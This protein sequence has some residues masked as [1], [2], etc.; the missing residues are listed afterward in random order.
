ME[1]TGYVHRDIRKIFNEMPIGRKQWT[2]FLICFAATAIEGFDTIVISFIAPAI[3]HQWQLSSAALSPLVAFGLS[4][5]L[6]GS[7]AGGTLAD[8]VG[9]RTVSIVAI[10]WFGIAG[11]VSS[12]AQSIVQLVALRFITGIGIGAAMPATSALVAEYSPDRSRSAM[13]ASTYCGFLFGAAAAGFVTSMAIGSLG[14]RGMLLLS[15]LMPLI[16][17]ALLAWQ[18]P[19]SPLYIVA[20]RK[21]NEVAHRILGK[22]F[23]SSDFTGMHL[24]IAETRESIRGSRAL[25]SDAYR[26]GTVL[27]WVTE[28]AGYLV[29]FLI[30]SWLPTH[31][32]QAGLSMHDASQISSM[33]QFGA[34]GGAVLFAFLVR[35]Y[36]VATVIAGAFGIGALLVIVLGMSEAAPWHV[37]VVFLSGL[38]VGGPLICVNTIPGIF[39]PTALRASGGGWNVAIGRLG[40]IVGSSLIGLIVL[41]GFPFLFTCALLSIPLLMACACMTFM[42][43]V[44]L[45]QRRSQ[46]DQAMHNGTVAAGDPSLTTGTAK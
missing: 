19:E 40:S 37:G 16:V 32:K 17:V 2:V 13:L 18:V 38:A 26:L 12:E 5:L 27:T 6:I 25:L 44:L 45:E 31:L 14:W 1:S 29:F 43:R 11:V 36:S 15:G 21:S 3:S 10:A 23:P 4:G 34:L 20:S 7:I 24:I 8:R 42:R 41:S 35:R 28:F 22:V 46:S 33:F 30:G 39:Y 9:R